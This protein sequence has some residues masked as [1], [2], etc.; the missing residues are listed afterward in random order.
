ML[1][2]RSVVFNKSYLGFKKGNREVT[3]LREEKS[4]DFERKDQGVRNF[5]WRKTEKATRRE[6]GNG[7]KQG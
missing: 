7:G 5:A 1:C 2:F 4:E 6:R 3:S